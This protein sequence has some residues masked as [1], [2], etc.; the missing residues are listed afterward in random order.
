MGYGAHEA[1]PVAKVQTLGLAELLDEDVGV[2]GGAN[3]EAAFPEAH[4]SVA[5]G[6]VRVR[7]SRPRVMQRELAAH[8]VKVDPGVLAAQLVQQPRV[9]KVAHAPAPTRA[10]ALT[11]THLP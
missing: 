9:D 3:E 10:T 6:V 5:Q 7:L 11:P 8:S 4:G 2:G 1:R